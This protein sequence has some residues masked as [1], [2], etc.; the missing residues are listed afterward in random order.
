[1]KEGTDRCT[2]D[3]GVKGGEHQTSEEYHLL[4]ASMMPYILVERL[5]AVTITYLIIDQC[6][7][8]AAHTDYVVRRCIGILIGLSRF[9][10]SIT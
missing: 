8:F 10:L 3:G 4:H 9:N 2:K 5:P 1:M 7:T 6:M